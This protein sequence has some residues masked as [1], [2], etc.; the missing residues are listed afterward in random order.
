MSEYTVTELGIK[1]FVESNRVDFILQTPG[2]DKKEFPRVTAY[3]AQP[4]AQLLLGGKE[5]N[6]VRTHLDPETGAIKQIEVNFGRRTIKLG[7]CVK[8][9]GTPSFYRGLE[10]RNSTAPKT[11][12]ALADVLSAW[13]VAPTIEDQGPE[14]DDFIDDDIPF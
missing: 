3:A 8:S 6:V 14:A 11:E 5:F 4:K 13:N 1:A 7:R 12:E 2:I 9:P 10:T